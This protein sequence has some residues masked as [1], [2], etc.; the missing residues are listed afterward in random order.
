MESLWINLFRDK[1]KIGQVRIPSTVGGPKGKA[2]P[3]KG[4]PAI[5]Y[6]II[7]HAHLNLVP[8]VFVDLPLSIRV[9]AD[10]RGA[11]GK[12]RFF[13]AEIS[14]PKVASAAKSAGQG[15]G[16]QGGGSAGK[17]QARKA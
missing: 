7:N 4:Q 10:S 3:E 1:H 16:R 15:K 5:K 12:H 9:F 17:K 14:K 6:E 11:G 13:W 8:G 2:L